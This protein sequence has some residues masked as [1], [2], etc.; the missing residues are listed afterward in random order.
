MDNDLMVITFLISCFITLS[1]E[2]GVFY[3]QDMFRTLPNNL[4]DNN[5]HSTKEGNDETI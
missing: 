3:C 1:M 5:K 2:H 4:Q